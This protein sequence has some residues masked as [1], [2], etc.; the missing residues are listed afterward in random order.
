MIFPIQAGTLRENQVRIR[1][2]GGAGEFVSH[3][4]LRC[5]IDVSLL[6]G[7]WLDAD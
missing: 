5:P 3:L 4:A 2:V 1:G 7:R 6:F